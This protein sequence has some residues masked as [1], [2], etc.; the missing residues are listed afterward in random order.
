MHSNTELDATNNPGA[1]RKITPRHLLK[2]VQALALAI[3]RNL[4]RMDAVDVCLVYLLLSCRSHDADWT[5]KLHRGEADL[6]GGVLGYQATLQTYGRR[7]KV[8]YIICGSALRSMER[9]EKA[10][11]NSAAL[12]RARAILNL[13]TTSIEAAVVA[14]AQS[15]ANA[16]EK[17]EALKPSARKS[18]APKAK[19]RSTCS[20][21]KLAEL[22]ARDEGLLKT[23]EQIAGVLPTAA[24]ELADRCRDTGASN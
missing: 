12:E 23:A 10:L 19:R 16:N 3:E 24:K 4:A 20:L 22:A 1:R 13:P 8:N 11:Q 21:I 2:H 17:L 6:L 18:D 14:A 5:L 7:G 9:I 15:L